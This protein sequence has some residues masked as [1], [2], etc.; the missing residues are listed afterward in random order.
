MKHIGE[1]SGWRIRFNIRDLF[2]AT[3]VVAL[4]CGGVAIGGVT[5]PT[6]EMASLLVIVPTFVVALASAPLAVITYTRV[7]F[8]LWGRRSAAAWWLSGAGITFSITT[9][10]AAMWEISRRVEATYAE[11]PP[12]E[13][14]CYVVAAAASGHRRWV[15]TP[16]VDGR[17]RANR[18]LLRLKC[19]ELWLAAAMPLAHRRFR[20][21]YDRIGPPLARLVARSP[22]IADVAYLSLKPIEYFVAGVI[23]AAR[24]F[25]MCR[26]QNI[27]E[28]SRRSILPVTFT[29][30]R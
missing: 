20:Q 28:F 16:I 6:L 24:R 7:A 27:T 13:P 9:V 23:G 30:A 8:W 3:L 19:L 21:S 5:E 12:T 2:L 11:L 10:A 1:R 17:R 26:G 29:N 25:S 22:W 14:K 15:G 18:Q 4:I